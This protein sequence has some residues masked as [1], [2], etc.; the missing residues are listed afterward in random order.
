MVQLR[1]C[2][3]LTLNGSKF[4]QWVPTNN[5]PSRQPNEQVIKKPV[6]QASREARIICGELFGD[7]LLASIQILI[8][9]KPFTKW[10]DVTFVIF[11]IRSFSIWHFPIESLKGFYEV[12]KRVLVEEIQSSI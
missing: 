5:Q 4:Y 6:A 7:A 10:D 1:F 11:C 8:K 2:Y 12:V 9:M 3:S